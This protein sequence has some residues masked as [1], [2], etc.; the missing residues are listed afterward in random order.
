MNTFHAIILDFDGVLAESVEVKK[1]AFHDLFSLYPCHQQKMIE[2]YRAHYHTPRWEKFE[3]Y[4]FT[5]MER[6]GDFS[7]VKKMARQFSALV[8]KQVIDCPEVPGAAQFLG[9]FSKRLPLYV[10]SV[11]PLDELNEIL[12]GRKMDSFFRKVFGDP[13]I[14]KSEAIRWVLKK[15]DLLPQQVLFVG[16]SQSDF[17]VAKKFGLEF[18]GRDSGLPF[19]GVDAQV[20][21]DLVEIGDMIRNRIG[22]KN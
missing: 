21:D 4:V 6:P 1:Q 15:E 19:D 5:I 22:V 2:Y 11:T 9:E 16:D 18:V 10:S 20:F 12:R 14:N 3:H 7:A 13:P 8:K 17:S